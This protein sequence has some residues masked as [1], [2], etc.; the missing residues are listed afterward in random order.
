[1]SIAAVFAST[2]ARNEIALIPYVTA[3]YPSVAASLDFVQAAA[4]AGADAIEIGLPFSD[5]V[6]DGPTIQ[7]ASHEALVNGFTVR[8]FLTDLKAR[9]KTCP[10]IVMTY[11]NPL[12]ALG[13]DAFPLLA[14][15]GIRALVVPDLPEEEAVAV[16]SDAARFGIDLIL[17]VAP[18]SSPERLRRIGSRSKGFLYVVGV[19]GVTGARNEADPSLPALLDRV[20]ATTTLPLVAGFGLSDPAHVRAIA[21]HADGV[22]VGSRFVD[23]I[24]RGEDFQALVRSFK[25]ATRRH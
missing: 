19:V 11:L 2:R 15:A 16:S 23:A 18:T 12:L 4:E 13:K 9:P 14:E 20:R 10:L 1:M 17:L 7:A 3:G 8:P 5:P 22:I 24:R 21:A 6:A 25:T